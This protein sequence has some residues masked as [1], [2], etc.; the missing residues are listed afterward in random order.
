MAVAAIDAAVGAIL[1]EMLVELGVQNAF[2]KR[3]LQIVSKSILGKHF[4]R[5]APGKK[6][7]QKF[8]LDSHLMILLFSI[9]MASAQNF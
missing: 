7:V 2:R 6:L 5:I 4:L 3:L 1:N 9:I 8:F